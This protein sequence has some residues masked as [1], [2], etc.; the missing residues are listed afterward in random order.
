VP[1]LESVTYIA[2]RNNG[3]QEVYL[4][5]ENS[6]LELNKIFKINELNKLAM[7]LFTRET[8]GNYTSDPYAKN[9]HKYSKEMQEIRKELRKLDQ[10]TKKD[11]GVVDWNRMLNDFM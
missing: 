9:D 8:I 4:Y 1:I 3:A 5:Y 10:E 2:K 7:K 11:G 6:Y